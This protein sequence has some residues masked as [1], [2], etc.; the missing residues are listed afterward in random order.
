VKARLW[1]PFTQRRE[2]TIE[3]DGLPNP[4]AIAWTP[5]HDGMTDK[6]G[7]A[8]TMLRDLGFEPD[9][10]R[11]LILYVVEEYSLRELPELLWCTRKEVEQLRSRVNR[12][13]K[14]LRVNRSFLPSAYRTARFRTG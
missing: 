6:L 13:I 9:E 2:R 3:L 5:A 10:I 14:K 4:E 7:N 12:K 1:N 11:F 8:R